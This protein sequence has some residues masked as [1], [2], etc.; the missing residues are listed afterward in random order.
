MIDLALFLFSCLFTLLNILYNL[1]IY[2]CAYWLF[3][4]PDP[5]ECELYEKQGFLSFYFIDV[6][7]MLRTV[8]DI[9]LIQ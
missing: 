4:I 6:S 2:Y 3:S 5:L 1:L 8:T 7:Q 9:E